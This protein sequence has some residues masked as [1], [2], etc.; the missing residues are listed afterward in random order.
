MVP[1]TRAPGAGVNG[2]IID[3]DFIEVEMHATWR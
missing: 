1:V 2:L 3:E